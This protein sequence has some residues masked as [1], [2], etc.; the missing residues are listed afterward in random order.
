MSQ[1]SPISTIDR[2]KVLREEIGNLR[3]SRIEQ[4]EAELAQLR[5][6]A[7]I[8]AGL[9]LPGRHERVS[10][11]VSAAAHM[12]RVSAMSIT[13]ATRVRD[14][15]RARFAVAWVA[16]E[17]FGVSSTEIGRA[18]GDRDHSTILWAQCRAEQWRAEDDVYR[19]ATS[20]L[21][22]MFLP[23]ELQEVDDALD[24]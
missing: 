23:R 24:S 15:C 18:L 4:I 1:L 11:I 16:R 3:V 12:F 17:A 7:Y 5:V 14:V 10:Q 20:G 21:L 2:I 19:C 22:A 6:E 13:G 9:P 8:R